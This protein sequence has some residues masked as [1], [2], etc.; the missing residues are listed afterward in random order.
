MAP[1]VKHVYKSSTS[2]NRRSLT[3]FERE[4]KEIQAAKIQKIQTTKIQ[5]T[6]DLNN[7]DSNKKDSINKDS[8]NKNS[9]DSSAIL[10]SLKGGSNVKAQQNKFKNALRSSSSRT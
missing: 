5:L 7:K 9:R 10:Q 4:K 1:R 6:K 2:N 3:L 8:S